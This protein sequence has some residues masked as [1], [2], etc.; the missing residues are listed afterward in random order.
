MSDPQGDSSST[1]NDLL[2]RLVAKHAQTE[3]NYRIVAQSAEDVQD[4]D[5]AP[6]VS[7]GPYLLRSGQIRLLTTI[8]VYS[9]RGE[10]RDQMR[11]LYMN[12]VAIRVWQEMGREPR[13]IGAQFR[14]PQAALL[15]FGVPFCN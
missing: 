2:Y 4:T 6:A 12:A 15:S 3:E 11:L 13:I 7:I 8:S 14:P 1:S 5:N 9:L 10:S